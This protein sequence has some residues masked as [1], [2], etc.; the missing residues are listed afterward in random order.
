MHDG[1]AATPP[2]GRASLPDPKPHQ[3]CEECAALGRLLAAAAA[4]VDRSSATDVRI[5]LRR[6]LAEQHSEAGQVRR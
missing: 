1:T 2:G 5:L 6:H 3:G 4:Q